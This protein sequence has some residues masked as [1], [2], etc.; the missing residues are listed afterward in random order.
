MGGGSVAETGQRLSAR[1]GTRPRATEV[2][3]WRQEEA[4]G[5]SRRN[6]ADTIPV[7]SARHAGCTYK[8]WGK[9]KSST[10]WSATNSPNKRSNGVT[11]A[12][13]LK[14]KIRSS[15]GTQH[16]LVSGGK[17]GHRGGK[18]AR[19]G[20]QS[21]SRL[22]NKGSITAIA[23][24]CC[25]VPMSTGEGSESGR[26]DSR[27]VCGWQGQ[28]STLPQLQRLQVQGHG[29]IRQD[30]TESGAAASMQDVG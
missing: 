16:T 5:C 7:A 18:E 15:A 20:A 19:F 2:Y 10:R 30:A 6:A 3:H 9:T 21:K 28:L 29:A 24:R 26:G 25:R 4:Q 27:A 23:L 17:E 8:S 11:K 1:L 22:E 14:Q 12:G 13:L